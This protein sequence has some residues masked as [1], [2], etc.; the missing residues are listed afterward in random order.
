MVNLVKL[1][2]EKY[3]ISPL[4]LAD[5]GETNRLHILFICPIFFA[6]GVGDLIIIFS[7]HFHHLQNY[8]LSIAYFGFF[9]V[10][11]AALYFYCKW[12][13]KIS[14][15]KSYIL[16][17]IP[18]YILIY[19]GLSAAVYN[20]Y[21]LKQPFNGVIA[22]C[23]SGFISI[24]SFSF[25]PIFFFIAITMGLAFLCPGV[26][27]NFGITGLLDTI[28]TTIIMHCFSLYRRFTDKKILLAMKKQKNNLEAK[29]FGN[30]TLIYD[31]K[32][33]KFSRSK[34][35]ELMGYLIYKN[36]SS[37]NS[38][39]LLA[40]LW[41]DSADSSRYGSNLR[42]LVVDVKHTFS[43]LEINNF[44]ITEYNSFRINP[45]A[46]KCDYY[47]FLAGDPKAVKSFTG[48]FMNQYSWAEEV[49]GFLE[50]KTL[51]G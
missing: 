21:V 16:K 25:S 22:Y 47:D 12:A 50:K 24:L 1:Y 9:T 31:N 35:N 45:E 19:I 17:T 29:T 5:A 27:A 2:K 28:L 33:V 32:V 36:G 4:D 14:R 42:N 41:G 13:K 48:E 39:E 46:I 43:D 10:S 7:F 51:Q 37:V 15:E 34:S 44:F 40:V 11:S 20:F 6:F 23:L 49:V 3:Y 30:F 38:K 8:I 26:Y 18:I